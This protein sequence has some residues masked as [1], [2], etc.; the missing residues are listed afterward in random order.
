[1]TQLY[2]GNVTYSELTDTVSGENRLYVYGS[3]ATPN[4]PISV[5]I[6][7]NSTQFA[8][9]DVTSNPNGWWW[10]DTTDI[11]GF[12]DAAGV[13]IYK[14]IIQATAYDAS[15]PVKVMSEY[16]ADNTPIQGGPTNLPTHYATMIA[17]T[18]P[19][20]P[21][22]RKTTVY[23]S[24]PGAVTYTQLIPLDREKDIVSQNDIDNRLSTFSTDSP[25]LGGQSNPTNVFEIPAM[26][27]TLNVDNTLV[28]MSTYG[29][30]T[31]VTSLKPTSAGVVMNMD[32][33][34]PLPYYILSYDGTGIA[35][36]TPKVLTNKCYKEAFVFVALLPN[37]MTKYPVLYSRTTATHPSFSNY[38]ISPDLYIRF[39]G[40]ISTIGDVTH[41]ARVLDVI[42]L[43]LNDSYAI[44]TPVNGGD[45]GAYN[46]AAQ[47]V[48][49][50]HPAT[51]PTHNDLQPYTITG[52]VSILSYV[53]QTEI[54]HKTYAIS[55]T[56]TNDA[57]LVD[58]VI[59]RYNFNYNTGYVTQ[60]DWDQQIVT[61]PVITPLAATTTGSGIYATR[62]KSGTRVVGGSSIALNDQYATGWNSHAT[63]WNWKAEGTVNG[64]P[65][66]TKTTVHRTD[67]A[68]ANAESLPLTGTGTL[69]LQDEKMGI[70]INPL[71]ITMILDRYD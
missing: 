14:C 17:G 42:G 69:Y 62:I 1:M 41:E 67:V 46:Q 26:A 35:S 29:T 60:I 52:T 7:I 30:S 44:A 68:D 48:I 54:I 8:P 57:L 63:F 39:S 6:T 27:W 19:A 37:T 4:M 70:F 56:S 40:N 23:F 3:S 20:N 5:S 36:I 18:D 38:G 13:N 34:S 32:T 47:L 59:G 21:T 50:A 16:I 31:P 10:I 9:V 15:V 64:T 33:G 51:S 58:N 22:Q 66:S 12:A 43:S 65:V 53:G 28:D 24:N 25:T 61:Q 55:D 49:G 71:T 2:A 11:P 45:E